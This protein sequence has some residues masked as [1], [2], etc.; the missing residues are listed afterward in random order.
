MQGEKEQEDKIKKDF[1][2]RFADVG[3]RRLTYTEESK[4]GGR[5]EDLKRC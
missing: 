1:E 3:S 5:G 2:D 4:G